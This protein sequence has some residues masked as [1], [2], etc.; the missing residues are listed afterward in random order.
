MQ[1]LLSWWDGVELWLSGL[2]FVLQTIIVMPVV[3]LIAYLIALVIDAMLGYGIRVL[4][5]LRR[6][7]RRLK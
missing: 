2:G 6:A 4:R 3:L 1:G 5:R 7:D